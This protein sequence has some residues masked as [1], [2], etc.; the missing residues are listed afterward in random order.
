MLSGLASW[1]T[2]AS[3]GA[4]RARP[5]R[6]RARARRPVRQHRGV[7]EQGSASGTNVKVVQADATNLPFS[8][9]RFSAATC[10]TMLHHVRTPVLQDRLMVE[11]R[12]LI[13]PRWN[14][15]LEL[16]ASRRRQ[17]ELHLGDV[18]ARSTLP[19]GKSGSDGRFCRGRGGEAA[20]TG[21]ASSRRFPFR[22]LAGDHRRITV[23]PPCTGF[24]C[25][26]GSQPIWRTRPSVDLFILARLEISQVRVE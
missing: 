3:L 26:R 10:F 25:R 19:V 20:R 18:Y 7:A 8:S 11:L 4:R 13:A 2:A 16:T 5:R 17:A 24:G 15:S 21:S 22:S 23:Q 12:Q 6:R 9:A 1:R 14:M